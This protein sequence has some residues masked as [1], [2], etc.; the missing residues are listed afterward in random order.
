[1]KE[2]RGVSRQGEEEQ[3]VSEQPQTLAFMADVAFQ[4]P[5]ES[6]IPFGGCHEMG[7]EKEISGLLQLIIFK[8]AFLSGS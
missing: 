6:Y 7:G 5:V 2:G 8:Y 3:V 1:M 4:E